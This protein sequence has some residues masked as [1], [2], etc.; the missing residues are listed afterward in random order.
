MTEASSQAAGAFT[1]CLSFIGFE[2]MVRV[3]VG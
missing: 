3:K 2:V 1:V